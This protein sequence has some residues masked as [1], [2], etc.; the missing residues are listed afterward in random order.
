[1]GAY[2]S[3]DKAKDILM[4]NFIDNWENNTWKFLQHKADVLLVL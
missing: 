2:P 3:N 1:M 4:I